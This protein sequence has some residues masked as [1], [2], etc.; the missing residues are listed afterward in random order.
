MMIYKRLTEDIV[1]TLLF[2]AI[3]MIFNLAVF[4]VIKIVPF[5]DYDF[6]DLTKIHNYILVT[7]SLSIVSCLVSLEVNEFAAYFRE[8]NTKN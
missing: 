5:P 4:F 7:M 2:I 8:G 3:S 6:F 1:F